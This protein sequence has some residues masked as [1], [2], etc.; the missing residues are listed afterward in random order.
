MSKLL[1]SHLPPFTTYVLPPIITFGMQS[2][3]PFWNKGSCIMNLCHIT[4]LF[5]GKTNPIAI[6]IMFERGHD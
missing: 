2:K 4:I 1:I 5:L 3:V 6:L